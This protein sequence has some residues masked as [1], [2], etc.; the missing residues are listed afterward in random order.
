MDKETMPLLQIE[1]TWKQTLQKCG[2]ND[3]LAIT[4]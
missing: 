1:N 2:W 4:Y 3:S